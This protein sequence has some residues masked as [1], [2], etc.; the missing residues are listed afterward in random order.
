MAATAT[1]DRRRRSGDEVT[2]GGERASCRSPTRTSG[3]R[4]SNP[5]T[6]TMTSAGSTPAA[7]S[8]FARGRPAGAGRCWSARIW[9]FHP[10]ARDPELV[11]DGSMIEAP[12]AALQGRARRS[13]RQDVRRHRRHQLRGGRRA[14]R[15]DG[16]HRRAAPGRASTRPAPRAKPPPADAAPTAAAGGVGVQ[17][18][19]YSTQG[20]GRGRLERAVAPDRRA[21]GLQPPHRRGPADSGTVYRLQA[22][23]GSAA[24]R[25]TRCAPASRPPGGD[26]QVKR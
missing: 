22:V 21:A 23:A 7:S 4:G 25:Q 20:S 5:T 3:C 8:R 9:W 15:V 6:T 12:D 17:V 13:R 19:A 18:G 24:E 14:R 11:A 10:R 1:A 26:C 16:R 2:A